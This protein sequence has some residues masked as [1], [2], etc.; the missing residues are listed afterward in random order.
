MRTPLGERL[1]QENMNRGFNPSP[2][3]LGWPQYHRRPQD[4]PRHLRLI[5]WRLVP[6]R[7]ALLVRGSIPQRMKPRKAR[8]H[9]IG[10]RNRA[11]ASSSHCPYT[12][13]TR[14]RIQYHD[15][16]QATVFSLLLHHQRRAYRPF[17]RPSLTDD[18]RHSHRLLPLPN[19]EEGPSPKPT[20][21]PRSRPLAR[22]RI[23][24][25]GLQPHSLGDP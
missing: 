5:A 7:R 25:Q 18:N 15:R 22:V 16:Q 8:G 6:S 12:E 10:N 14:K 17:L 24:I 2:S 13:S 23:G 1:N 11:W 21:T 3:L 20:A 19:Q 4:T 9:A